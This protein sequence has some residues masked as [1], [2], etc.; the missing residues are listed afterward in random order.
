MFI[1]DEDELRKLTG[2]IRREKQCE[3]LREMG[4]PFAV[5]M[6][7]KPIVTAD[8]VRSM[9]GEASDESQDVGTLNLGVVR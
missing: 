5:R 1:L 9:T 4:V 8:A 7:G 3:A 6:D 2:K